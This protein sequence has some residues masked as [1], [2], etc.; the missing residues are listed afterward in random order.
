ML[1]THSPILKSGELE[2]LLGVDIMGTHRAIIDLGE[3]LLWLK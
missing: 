3:S 1:A 2:G